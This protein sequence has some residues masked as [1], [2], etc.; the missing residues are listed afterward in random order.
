MRSS[1]HKLARQVVNSSDV[2][3]HQIPAQTIYLTHVKWITGKS[4]FAI[5]AL[6]R[7]L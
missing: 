6:S 1:L 5:H 4:M 7:L 3:L 2:R